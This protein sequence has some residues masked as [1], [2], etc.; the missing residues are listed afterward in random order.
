MGWPKYYILAMNMF[1][2]YLITPRS[3]HMHWWKGIP[4]MRRRGGSH[5]FTHV[6]RCDASGSMCSG[7]IWVMSTR[8]C[9]SGWPIYWSRY[10]QVYQRVFLFNGRWTNLQTWQ[11][12]WAPLWDMVSR[13][14]WFKYTPVRIYIFV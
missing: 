11:S 1:M 14:V 13:A 7:W 10:R 12:H 2:W 5:M 9:L 4:H 6:R 3:T 8:M